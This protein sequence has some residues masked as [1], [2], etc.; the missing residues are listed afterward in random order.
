MKKS[1]LAIGV[2]AVLVA[3][4]AGGTWYSGKIL[5]QK[6]PDYIKTGNENI[7][8]SYSAALGENIKL[9][10]KNV[11]FERGF[12]SSTIEDQLIITDNSH[13]GKQFIVPFK[14]VA[15]HGPIPLSRLT[16]LHWTPVMTAAKTEILEDPSISE[17][18]K[19]SKGVTPLSSQFTISYSEQIQQKTTIAAFDYQQDDLVINSTPIQIESD[20]NKQGVG[21]IK[22]DLDHFTLSANA[23]KWNNQYEEIQVKRDLTLHKVKLNS[24]LTPSKWRYVPSGKQLFTIESFELKEEPVENYQPLNI[25]LKNILLDYD[26]T[27]SGDNVNYVLNNNIDEVSIRDQN[28]GKLV[29]NLGLGHLNAE[30]LNNMMEAYTQMYNNPEEQQQK[31]SESG[32]ALLKNQ[33]TLSLQPFSLKNNAGENKLALDI[34]MS[35]EDPSAV[36]M[37]GKI[38]SLFDKFEFNADVNK[39]AAEQFLISQEIID[40]ATPAEQLAEVSAKIKANLAQ[41]LESAVQQKM[42]ITSDNQ[43]YQSKLILENGQLKL[44]GET[45]PEEVI[46]QT[47]LFIFMGGF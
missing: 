1:S 23:T 28:F 44:N 24:D 17:L 43:N 46:T 8:S 22:L 2:V 6:Y 32:L 25:S 39:A 15:E 10:V 42:L 37:Q 5:E 31:L 26:T 19:A 14:T 18:F 27:L 11:R 33:P 29:F 13:D 41:Q 7:H 12:F 34:A 3:A 30:N 21:L 9:E 47:L 36:L 20:T 38:L 40:H 16:S 35:K 45:V 4:W